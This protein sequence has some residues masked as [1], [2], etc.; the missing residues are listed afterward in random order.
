MRL[1]VLVACA[2]VAQL[3]AAFAGPYTYTIMSRFGFRVLIVVVHAFEFWWCNSIV[4]IPMRGVI[5]AYNYL[6]L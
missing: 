1:C 6:L 5:F 3:Q 4:A 2:T